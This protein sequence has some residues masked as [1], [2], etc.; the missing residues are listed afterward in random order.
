MLENLDSA[1]GALLDGLRDLGVERNT[2]VV[3][4]S[5]NG[6]LSGVTDNRPLRG[7][8][9]SL[10][11]GGIRVP[12]IV[13]WPDVVAPGSRCAEPVISQDVH[14]ALCDV[15]GAPLDADARA[16]SRSLVPLLDGRA[17]TLGRDALFWHFPQYEIDE[18]PPRGAV[19]CGD[20]KLLESFADGSTLLYGLRRD[21]SETRDLSAERPEVAREMLAKLRAWR[22]AVGAAMPTPRGPAGDTR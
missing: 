8:K 10:W 4:T 17:T 15:V 2:L 11:E 19:R 16:D 7:G 13:R 12:L 6:G 5:D 3:F 9:R 22:R 1:V 20:W 14:A 18:T 21:P